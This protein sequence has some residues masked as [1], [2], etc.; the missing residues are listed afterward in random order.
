[1]RSGFHRGAG[2]VAGWAQTPSLSSRSFPRSGPRD[3]VTRAKLPKEVMSE[4][5]RG[6]PWRAPS[7]SLS[8]SVPCPPLAVTGPG[9]HEVKKE[10][11]TEP[12]HPRTLSLRGWGGHTA[13]EC[14]S[15][16]RQSLFSATWDDTRARGTARSSVLDVAAALQALTTGMK[17]D[18]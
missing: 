1:M 18:K 9:S 3:V 13:L 4:K 5:L 16:A 11:P 12:S 15:P 14:K 7:S 8:R 2:A 6:P 10:V 17:G